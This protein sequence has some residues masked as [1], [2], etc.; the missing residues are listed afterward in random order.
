[1]N[2]NEWIASQK[3][4][5]VDTENHSFEVSYFEEGSGSDVTLFLHGIPTWSFLF[6]DIYS[7]ATHAIIPDLAGY[8]FTKHLGNG[9]YD[10]SLRVQG[11]LITEFLNIF[12]LDSVTIVGHDIG[13]GIALRLAVFTDVVKSLVL[14]NSVCYDNW[15]VP[16]IHE[17]GVPEIVRETT[18]RDIEEQFDAVFT[19]GTYGTDG[20]DEFVAGM[21]APFSAEVRSPTAFGRNAISTNTNHTLEISSKLDS[22]TCPT[23]L[24]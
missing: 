6:R 22:I 15:P 16:F 13:G 10:R 18:V 23:L 17:Q 21:N 4:T 24:L 12:D 1:M 19:Q 9:G 8:G 14:S 11:K 2:Y 20:N 7:V 3:S 5:I